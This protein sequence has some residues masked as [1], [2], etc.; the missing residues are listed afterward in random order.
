ME[1]AGAWAGGDALSDPG[2][3][4]IG[5]LEYDA[6]R[7]DLEELSLG[8]RD[9]GTLCRLDVAQSQFQ[10]HKDKYEKLRAD[11]AIKLKFLEENKVWQGVGGSVH[12]PRSWAR[13]SAGGW[14]RD[15]AIAGRW[16]WRSLDAVCKGRWDGRRDLPG[17][18]EVWDA[19]RVGMV[20]GGGGPSTDCTGAGKGAL[21]CSD[22]WSVR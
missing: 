21:S 20:F 4:P 9:A 18:S 11:V 12:S 6:Y 10:S 14:P 19:P 16:V 1:G 13:G 2:L 17:I 3:A 22:A 5:R 8:P 7:T 15:T